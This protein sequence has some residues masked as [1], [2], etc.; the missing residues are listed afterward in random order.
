MNGAPLERS[1]GVVQATALVVG[2]IIGASIFVQ[3]SEITRDVPTVGGILLVWLVAGLLSTAGALICAELA[4]AYPETGGVYVYL[5]RTIG[6]PLAFLWGW[7]MF[8]SMHSGIIAAI[9]VIFA[10]YAGHFT[11]LDAAA[12]QGVAV[13]A[14]F[15]VSAV[16]YLGVRHGSR[17]QA[18]FTIG[19]V[20]AVGL[21]IVLGFT[22]GSRLGAPLQTGDVAPAGGVSA[23]A[24][25]VAAGLFAFGGWHMVTYT[26]GETRDARR[27]IPRAL[28]IGMAIVIACYIALNAVYLYVLPIE[29]VVASTRVAADAADAVLGRGGAS[30]MAALVMFSTLGSLAGLVLAGPRVY[31]SMAEDGL[32]FRWI[33][34]SHPRYRTPHRAIALQAVWSSV[35]IV[36]GS[37]RA[38]FTRVV[39]TEWIFFA[40]LAVGLLLV[41]RRSSYSP[42]YRMR[43]GALVPLLFAATALLIVANQLAAQPRDSIIGLGLVLIG[44]PVYAL[45][46]RRSDSAP[47]ASVEGVP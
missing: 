43:G 13:A 5:R 18:A 17:L 46:A 16:N 9:A 22:L 26:A 21:M 25:A 8:W 28:V 42:A 36:T 19:K 44:L 39:Y 40:L 12:T 29:R 23:F 47:P 37:Y 15:G 7:A 3:P 24:R 1:I 35:L 10:R 38:L 34:R 4:S 31:Y 30:F 6:R 27:T 33:G 32:L 41:R 45:W 14:V 2:I 11:E 20:A